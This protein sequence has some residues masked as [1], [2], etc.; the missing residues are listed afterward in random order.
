DRGRPAR[1]PDAE[2]RDNKVVS[3]DGLRSG[4]AIIVADQARPGRSRYG[5]APSRII[6]PR[7]TV[8]A[9]L[10]TATTRFQRRTRAGRVAGARAFGSPPGPPCLRSTVAGSRAGLFQGGA[11]FVLELA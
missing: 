9:I 10:A 5:R 4:H 8:S 2:L 7:S 3:R 1:L 6:P 11:E